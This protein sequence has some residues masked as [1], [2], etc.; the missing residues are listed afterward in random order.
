M[1]KNRRMLEEDIDAQLKACFDE[2]FANNFELF[3]DQYA[4][5]VQY[6]NAYKKEVSNV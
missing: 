3:T 2:A 4:L 5:L 1:E 6:W